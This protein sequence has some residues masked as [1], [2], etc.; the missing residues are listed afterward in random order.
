MIEEEKITDKKT[1]E[2]NEIYKKGR[3]KKSRREIVRIQRQMRCEERKKER[4]EGRD[5]DD[6]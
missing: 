3:G 4:K 6:S 5:E 2:R 1:E